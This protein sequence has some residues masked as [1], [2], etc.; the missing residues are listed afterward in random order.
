MAIPTNN[1]GT[2]IASLA[3][4]FKTAPYLVAVIN[5]QPGQFTYGTPW[6][7][8]INGSRG[9]DVILAG[10]GND[11][12]TGGAD[13]DVID[14]G[15]G[16]DSID[17]GSDYDWLYGGSGDDTLI[18]GAGDDEIHGQT[19]NDELTGGS[20][21]DRFWFDVGDGNDVLTDYEFGVDDL[22]FFGENGAEVDATLT[23]TEDG[24]LM[25]WG[26]QGDTLLLQGIHFIDT[27][28]FFNVNF[29]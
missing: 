29:V 11:T 22:Y 8:V 24:L 12:V 26:D 18:G 15:S 1:Y 21:G 5:A 19:G 2:S 4:Q 13:H 23:V 3:L 6:S 10:S 25:A 7:D 28:D 17:G 20:G 9:P 16:N 27:G 14:G